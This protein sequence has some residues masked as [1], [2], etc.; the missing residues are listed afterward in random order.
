MAN[1]FPLSSAQLADH[2]RVKKIVDELKYAL[3]KT[4][5]TELYGL[6]GHFLKD[7][8][9]AL[10]TRTG[11]VLN[12]MESVI[13]GAYRES[14]NFA[15]VVAE[16]GDIVNH[17]GNR[18]STARDAIVETSG[19]I[20]DNINQI[21]DTIKSNPDEAWPRFFA[22][23][24]SSLIVSGGVDGNGGAPDMDIVV[25]GIGDHRSLFTHS[26]LIGSALEA[27]I[28]TVIRLVQITHKN[29][30]LER[31]DF[32]DNAL[33]HSTNILKGVG[34]GASAGLA[35]HFLVDGIFQPGA[36]HGIGIEL[37]MEIHQAFQTI[38]AVGEGSAAFRDQEEQTDKEIEGIKKWFDGALGYQL[39][40]WGLTRGTQS[41]CAMQAFLS[42]TIIYNFIAHAISDS[43]YSNVLRPITLELKLQPQ[44]A[45]FTEK[46]VFEALP[47]VIVLPYHAP[48]ETTPKHERKTFPSFS[49]ASA[50]AKEIA[51]SSKSLFRV[52]KERD[53]WI[54]E[55]VEKRT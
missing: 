3:S 18:L 38:N 40:L 45:V 51:L 19:N 30:P 33:K 49:S 35:Y 29:L 32:W 23:V 34:E 6:A 24:L 15:S 4:E 16:K 8:G 54:V 25:L 28:K 13:K 12:L 46:V 26:I 17:I 41:K 1:T 44:P 22:V 10:V 14:A 2:D 50:H 42:T 47:K 48:K 55:K 43:K 11:N 27:A 53:Y 9:T 20:A 21:K 52:V 36:Y 7:G 5:S 39:Y 31:D 37:P